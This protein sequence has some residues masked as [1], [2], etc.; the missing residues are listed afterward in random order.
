MAHDINIALIVILAAF[1]CVLGV[2]VTAML[3]NWVYGP[4]PK[5]PEEKKDDEE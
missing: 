5:R 3:F 2:T 4:D 1:W